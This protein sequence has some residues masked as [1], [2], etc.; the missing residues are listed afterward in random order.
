MRAPYPSDLSG[1][2]WAVLQ[3]LIPSAKPGGRPRAYA[4][5]GLLD[6]MRYVLRGRDDARSRRRRFSTARVPK[7]RKKGPPGWDGAKRLNGRKRHLLVDTGGCVLDRDPSSMGAPDAES[8]G[9]STQSAV[10]STTR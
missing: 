7:P 5:S 8:T 2:E 1:T 3:P 4:D 9:A 6:A 10:L